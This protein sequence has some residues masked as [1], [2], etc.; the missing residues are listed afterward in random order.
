MYAGITGIISR[1]A[2]GSEEEKLNIMLK[3]M[4]HEPFYTSGT[5]INRTWAGISAMYQ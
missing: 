5:Y 4:L 1:H 2:A 3:S